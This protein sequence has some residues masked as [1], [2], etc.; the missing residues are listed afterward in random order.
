MERA[1]TVTT[2]AA[3]AV[4][5]LLADVLDAHGGLDRWRTFSQVSA[6]VVTGGSLWGMKGMD[7]DATPRVM[8]SAFRRQWTRTEPFGHP[9]WHMTYEPGRVA[10]ASKAGEIV[11]EQEN[12]RATFV[13]HAWETL[14]NPLQLAYFNG[15][16]MWTYYNLPFMLGE[17]GFSVT[18]IPSVTQDGVVLKGL[19]VRFPSD[20]HTHCAEQQLYFDDSGLLRRQDYDVDV[21][22]KTP[23]A[24]LVSDY[25]EVDGLRLP[26]TRRVFRRNL[27]GTLQRD[28]ILV[29][30]DLSE[31]E[32]S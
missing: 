3:V 19:R 30:A 14:W 20:V 32:L 25:V 13:G 15:Y 10:I 28:T 17:P 23:A 24:H 2:V 5:P 9:D 31:F 11:A 21:A 29:S 22:G 27:D 8:T 12:P 7:I 16:A 18:G 6:T 1:M 4:H 26:T